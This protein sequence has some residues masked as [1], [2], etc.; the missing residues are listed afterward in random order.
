MPR[1]LSSWDIWAVIPN[2]LDTRN[3]VILS[4]M[5][6]RIEQKNMET[7]IS[8]FKTVKLKYVKF[9]LF[10]KYGICVRTQAHPG[11]MV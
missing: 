8:I 1:I 9:L 3:T 4:S 11:L 5:D 2:E 10:W 7:L 6:I